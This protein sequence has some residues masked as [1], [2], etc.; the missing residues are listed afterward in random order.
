MPTITIHAL[1][2]SHLSTML[3]HLSDIHPKSSAPTLPSFCTCCGQR[4]LQG[5][6]RSHIVP[7]VSTAPLRCV[8][9]GHCV[10]STAILEPL[11]L[12][13][14]ECLCE[15]DIKRLPIFRMN[16]HG[17]WLPDGKL[18]AHQI[19]LILGFDLVIV[20][21]VDKGEWQHSLL[22]QVGFVLIQVSSRT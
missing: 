21:G 15:L 2:T 4:S 1:T 22:L 5:R 18:C 11:H 17:H 9:L 12:S 13:L 16:P 20:C 7:P 14:V 6:P 19:C 8:F 10:K 3:R